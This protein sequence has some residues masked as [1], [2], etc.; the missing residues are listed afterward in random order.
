MISVMLPGNVPIFAAIAITVIFSAETPL[1]E[2]LKT[3]QSF[4]FWV[5]LF[6][7]LAIVLV[8]AQ[9]AVWA[10]LPGTR[11]W[12]LLTRAGR[13]RGRSASPDP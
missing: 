10:F 8:A 1:D 5:T 13:S 7:P 11:P 12:T 3:E 6:I 2:L 9:I 4:G